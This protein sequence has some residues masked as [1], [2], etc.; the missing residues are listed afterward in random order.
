MRECEIPQITAE[1]LETLI[2]MHMKYDGP[3]HRGSWQQS[4]LRA[5]QE[6]RWCR[7][8]IDQLQTTWDS[9]ER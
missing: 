3:E 1:H 5:F 9:L 2:E 4:E 7:E 6:L 8:R